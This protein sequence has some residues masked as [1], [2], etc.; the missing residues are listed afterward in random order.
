MRRLNHRTRAR[1]IKEKGFQKFL[2]LS[3]ISEDIEEAEKN[4]ELEKLKKEVRIDIKQL[5]E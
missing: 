4:Q 5:S 1:F 3:S 2:I